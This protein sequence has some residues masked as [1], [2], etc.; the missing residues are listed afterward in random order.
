[1]LY[2]IQQWLILVLDLAV[3]AIAVILIAMITSLRDQF[4]GSSIG[5]ALNILLTLN[6]TLANALKMWTMTEISV[7]AVSRVKSFI[8][9]TPS[10]E[11]CVASSPI[12]PQLPHGWPCNGAVE[13]TDV[14]AGYEDSHSTT[15][16]L[17]NLTMSIKSGEKIAICG[18]SG[19]GKTSLIMVILQMFDHQSGR[20][21]IDGENLA[22][23]SRSTVR[24]RINVVPQ[25]PFFMSGTLRF[26]L[27]PYQSV[28][29]A[30]LIR[31]IER[32]G[33][34]DRVRVKGGLDMEFSATDW[35][36]GQR[37]LLALSRVLVKKS[38]LL[39]LDEATSR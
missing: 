20:I 6:Q 8:E 7:R 36:V 5:V 32:V 29:D 3:G 33:L 39:I 30:E 27:D 37:Q 18:P 13:F 24:S 28:V 23:I 25:D 12:S 22:E 4:N 19:S 10:E 15:P 38:A 21:S 16:I 2:S 31:A 9:D 35:S 11:R 1:M 14:T 17:K 34:W 26:N